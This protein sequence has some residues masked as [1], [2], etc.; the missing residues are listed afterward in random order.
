MRKDILS[1]IISSEKELEYD[2]NMNNI[3][4]EIEEVDIL[5][6]FDG[7]MVKGGIPYKGILIYLLLQECPFNFFKE[8]T[9][10]YSEYKKTQNPKE[11]YKL[12]KGCPVEI[13][14]HIAE[15]MH[16]NE[17]WNKLILNLNPQK[18]GVISRNSKRLISKYLELNDNLPASIKLIIANEPE[19]DNGKYTG[20]ANI[21]VSPINLN[22]LTR[23]KPYICGKEEKRILEKQD[24][25]I[26]RT[27]NSGL[28]ICERNKSY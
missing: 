21:F 27:S 24:I 6:D 13:L 15:S 28:Y 19:I 2:E 10:N 26:K 17:E 3:E 9:K 22:R 5:S 14:D 11:F 1:K 25:Y 7:T 18:V 12:F 20:E 23:T 8:I 16:Q 4:K